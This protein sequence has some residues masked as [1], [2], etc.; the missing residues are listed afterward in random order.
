MVFV[1]IKWQIAPNGSSISLGW[2]QWP[3]EAV[4]NWIYS[5]INEL[6]SSF[7]KGCRYLIFQSSTPS[8]MTLFLVSDR[9]A[10][11]AITSALFSR[12]NGKNTEL[13]YFF[14]ITLQFRA[15]WFNDFSLI[16]QPL[17]FK[18]TYKSLFLNNKRWE[19]HYTWMHPVVSSFTT[20]FKIHFLRRFL[21]PH[22]SYDFYWVKT[23]H[24]IAIKK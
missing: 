5:V 24:F 14:R 9:Q 16:E 3:L 11:C 22:L 15:L 21:K 8:L 6:A 20:W 2:I 4:S 19:I 18:E 1:S 10:D 17:A 23:Y 12:E 13:Q 7:H